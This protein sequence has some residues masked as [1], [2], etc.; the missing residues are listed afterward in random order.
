MP[1]KASDESGFTMIMTVIGITL[2]ML[3]AAV[4]VTAVTGSTQITGR[5]L[6]RKQAY[7]AALA[8]INEYSYHLHVKSDYW[9][10]C[11]KAVPSGETSALNQ[12]G[13]TAN[14]RPVPG[15]SGATYAL[16]LIPANEYKECIPG[17]ESATSS[18]LEALEPMRGTFQ[19]RATGFS[20]KARVSVTATFKPA[21]FLDYVYFTQLETSDPVTY[22][23]PELKAAAERQ[24][25]K[26]IYEGRYN[27][28]LKNLSG[29]MLTES[30]TTTTEERFAD[31]CDVISFVGA[32]NIEG[33]MHTNDAFAFCESPTLGRDKNDPVE[34]S[35]PKE[36][37]WFQT[38]E[39][40]GGSGCSGSNANVKGR[41]EINQPALIP[42]ATNSE[43]AKI[44]EEH[45][46][47]EGEVAIC[48]E[49]STLK[50]GA[51]KSC[52][53]T[54]LYEGAFPTNGVIY[55]GNK[56]NE[57]N[58]EYTPFNVSYESTVVNTCGNIN[59]VKGEY[60]RPLTIAAA[61]NVL[62]MSSIK[63]TTEEGML[64]L[65]ATNFIRIYHPVKLTE[66]TC[67]SS[68]QNLSGSMENPTIEAALLALQHSIIVDNYR[69]GPRL[70]MLT[71]KGALAQKYR[72]AVGTTG[73]TG[74]LKHYVYDNRFK[75]SEPPSFIEPVKS[76]WVIGR[77]TVE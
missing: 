28:P 75:S 48:M 38:K 18:M 47:F 67:N 31:F 16:E 26:T 1:V 9:T 76:D 41:F 46:R 73:G 6:A 65:I 30:G 25:T 2:V 40:L 15:G 52:T 8:G 49:G 43:L 33:P 27:T 22:G 51:G 21:S 60:A 11:T 17:L 68:S 62:I 12:M 36:K 77:E 72:G 23:I 74:Y 39:L 13:S 32:D 14:R 71:V 45:F 61:N 59:I 56:N 57:C 35:Y 64:G 66:G 55:D 53:A 58:A 19:V 24:C 63:K 3:L 44:A 29:Q 70:G 5:D 10:E 20:G 7:E 54:P 4:A 42:P 69:C 50:V 37:G 34:V